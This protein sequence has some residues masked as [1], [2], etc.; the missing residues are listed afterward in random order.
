MQVSSTTLVT[1]LNSELHGGYRIADL[2]TRYG[3]A[4]PVQNPRSNTLTMTDPVGFVGY[5]IS[6]T[7]GTD[8]LPVI[9]YYDF[10]NMGLKVAKCGNSACSSGNTITAIDSAGDVGWY[11]SITIGTDGLPAISYFD[12]TN[13]GLKVAK[14]ANPF[15]LNNWSRR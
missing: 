14:C 3:Q 4:S 6:I 9:S 8:G 11:T 2:D 12:G 7:I 15:C 5:Q 10:G 1:N 13:G